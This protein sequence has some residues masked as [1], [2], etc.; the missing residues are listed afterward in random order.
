MDKRVRYGALRG[1][2]WPRQY[3]L[4]SIDKYYRDAQNRIITDENKRLYEEAPQ[5]GNRG[6]GEGQAVSKPM[7]GAV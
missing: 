3:R 4:G 2:E 1:I 7:L 5:K 6:W